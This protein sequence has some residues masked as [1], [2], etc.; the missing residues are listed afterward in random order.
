MQI[1]PPLPAIL[2]HDASVVSKTTVSVSPTNQ[3]AQ[4]LLS[5]SIH[6]VQ[7]IWPHTLQAHLMAVLTPPALM[8]M[9]RNRSL[10]SATPAVAVTGS[11]P[12]VEA[13]LRCPRGATATTARHRPCTIY[14]LKAGMQALGPPV[15]TL[16]YQL[17]GVLADLNP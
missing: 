8:L 13:A 14:M 7:Y 1:M 5:L 3:L 9:S 17:V 6:P 2:W 10:P 4:L 12:V 15:W 16:Q 11:T